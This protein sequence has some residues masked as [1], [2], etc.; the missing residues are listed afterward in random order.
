VDHPHLAARGVFPSVPHPGRG[1][2]R[3]TATPF[4]V[5]GHPSVPGGPAPYRVGEHTRQVLRDILGYNPERIAEL[6]EA[7]A[8]QSA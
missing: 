8:V 2:V 1:S 5:D 3:V 4:H 6:E 7:G